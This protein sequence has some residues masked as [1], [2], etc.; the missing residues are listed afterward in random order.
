MIDGMVWRGRVNDLPRSTLID[1]E[2]PAGGT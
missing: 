1:D 2:H